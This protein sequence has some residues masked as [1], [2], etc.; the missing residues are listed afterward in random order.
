[1]KNCSAAVWFTGQGAKAFFEQQ[2]GKID[3]IGQLPPGL[4]QF[5]LQQSPARVPLTSAE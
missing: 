5:A 2:L 1:V 3:A 4:P